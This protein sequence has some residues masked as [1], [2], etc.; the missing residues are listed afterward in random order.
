ML[1]RAGLT[2]RCNLYIH[3]IRR[4]SKIIERCPKPKYDTGCTF[5]EIPQFPEDKQ[6]D[7][8]KP[9]HRTAS[10]SWKHVLVLLHGVADFESMPLKINLIPGS[11]ANEFEIHKRN[12]LSPK[13]PVLLS[14][15]ILN[16]PKNEKLRHQGQ[17]HKVLV[18]PEAKIVEFEKEHLSHFIEHYLLPEEGSAAT[19]YNPFSKSSSDIELKSIKRPE[20]FI[21]LLMVGDLVLVCGHTQRD[22]RCGKLAPLLTNEFAKVLKHENLENKVDLGLISHIGG[23][24][25]A[26][27]VIYFPK[28]VKACPVTWYGR[29]LPQNVQGIVEETIKN[30][31]IIS[32]LFR[33]DL[34]Q[35]Q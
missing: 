32:E 10:Q 35:I 4:F 23:H 14:N 13:H 21:E 3:T 6:I 25:Y 26:G 27:N 8:L 18:Y 11:L 33:G 9:L 29:V 22:I 7:F 16:N 34:A 31:R 30:K 24:A 20:L 28:D 1:G 5:C 12:R 15:I 2:K 19:T 17:T